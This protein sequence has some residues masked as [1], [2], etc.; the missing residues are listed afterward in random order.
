MTPTDGKTKKTKKTV[1]TR[2]GGTTPRKGAGVVCHQCRAENAADS[3]FCSRCAA[4]LQTPAAV[5]AGDIGSQTVR[6]STVELARGNRLAGRYEIMEEL[7]RGGMGKVFKVYDHKIGEIIALKLIRP[8]ISAQDKAIE[9]FKNELKFTRKITHRNICRMYDLGEEDFVHYI[10]ME[11]VAG[12]DL[13]RFV[14]RA[15]PLNLGKAGAIAGQICDGLAEAHRIGAVHRDL[16]PQN[17]M[18]DAEGNAKIMDF[19]IARFTEMDRMTGSGVMIGTPEYMSPEQAEVK[20]VDARS[21]LYSLGVVL[22]E[23]VTGKVPFEGETALSLAMKH[24]MEIPR[25]PRE[26]NPQVTAGL[27]ALIARCL[28]KDPARRYESALDLKKALEDV[29]REFSTGE[30][31]VLVPAATPSPA[32]TPSAAPIAAPSAAAP[33]PVMRPKKPFPLIPAVAAGVLVVAAVIAVVLFTKSGP[34]VGTA[35][36]PASTTVTEAPAEKSAEIPDVGLKLPDKEMPKPAESGPKPAAA[37]PKPKETK[38]TAS[39]TGAAAKPQVAAP[40]TAATEADRAAA[41]LASGR[42]N[43]AR[44]FAEKKRTDT[45]SG[46]FLAAEEMNRNGMSAYTRRKFSDARCAFTVAENIYGMF[47]DSRD[48]ASRVKAIMK[49][50]GRLREESTAALSKFPADPRLKDAQERFNRGEVAREKKDFAAAAR[51]YAAAALDYEKIRR[52]IRK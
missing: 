17:I 4:P 36:E 44:N 23:M 29:A 25:D 28:E 8:E 35:D 20:E 46:V 19:G 26:L 41:D 33:A 30:R 12:E 52:A 31:A 38:T 49:Y 51:E 47:A 6:A 34:P 24:K 42:M 43:G 21:D 15:G 5:E 32:P 9:R 3:R 16:K 2:A 11:Y 13:K 10:T 27:A 45:A 22:F 48:D 18:I 39:Q 1:S 40:E 37:D 14:K 50:V 7:G